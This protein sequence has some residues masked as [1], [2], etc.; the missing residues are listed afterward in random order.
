A[1]TATDDTPI[2][3]APT[4]RDVVTVAGPEA[5]AYLQGQLSQ[6]VAGLPVGESAAT[7]VLD[8]QGKVAGWG[9]IHRVGEQAFEIDTDPGAG[10]AWEARLRRFLLRTKA[11]IALDE[12][13]PAVAVRG[14]YSS[15]DL[16]VDVLPAIGPGVIGFD[17][18]GHGIDLVVADLPS[19]AVEVDAA[20]LEAHRIAA[21]VPRWGAELDDATIPATVGQ[22]VIDVSVSF[23]KGCYTGQELVARI[24]SR[25]GNV[26]QRLVRLVLEG[27]A[28]GAGAGVAVGGEE[29]GTVTSA[30]DH[31]DGGSVA[32]TFVHRSVEIGDE[33]LVATVDGVAARLLP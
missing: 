11:E 33:G 29:V 8:P 25:G 2:I 14:L 13:V 24:D 5:E 12:G 7:F 15:P 23:T 27:P 10:A 26:P 22:W 16:G 30:A 17:A 6:D 31:P 28:P 4:T 1:P 9:R 19:D 3:W 20:A 32:L 18:I 21:G